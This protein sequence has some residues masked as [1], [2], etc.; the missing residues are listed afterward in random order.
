M[1]P[2]RTAPLESDLGSY[3]LKE[4]SDQ[5]PFC[6]HYMDPDQTASLGVV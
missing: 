6:L 2:D 4:Q 5:G 1:D 3:C